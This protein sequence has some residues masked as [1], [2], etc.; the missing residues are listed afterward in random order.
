MKFR[1]LTLDFTGLPPFFDFLIGRPFIGSRFVLIAMTQLILDSAGFEDRLSNM[2]RQIAQRN[3]TGEHVLLVGIQA[4]GVRLAQRLSQRLQALWNHPVPFG[5][6]DVSMHRDDIEAHGTPEV[7]PTEIPGDLSGKTVLL[8]DDVI[9]SGRTTR[10]ALDALNDFGRP[11]KVQ[12]AVMVDR[13]HRELPIMPDYVG[14]PVTTTL[15]QRVDV[16]FA[17][18][19]GRDEILL[20]P[21]PVGV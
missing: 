13:G 6:V 8:T 19:A 15:E 10:A 21:R 2:A 20:V 7:R 18:D 11:Q 1:Q 14:L 17:E 12:L 4:G 5:M 3:G 9:F 16:R